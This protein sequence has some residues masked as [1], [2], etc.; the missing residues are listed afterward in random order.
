MLLSY[1]GT[2]SLSRLMQFNYSVLL[3]AF[4]IVHYSPLYD[5]LAVLNFVS[6]SSEVTVLCD[7]FKSHG[8]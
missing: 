8:V 2:Y 4:Y 5:L 1:C 6:S 7:L 3:V